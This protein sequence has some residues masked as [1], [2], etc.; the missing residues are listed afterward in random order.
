MAGHMAGHMAIFLG[1]ILKEKIIYYRIRELMNII[2][3]KQLILIGFSQFQ[4]VVLARFVSDLSA[5]KERKKPFAIAFEN[6]K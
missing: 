3:D 2:R 5:L 4:L 1:Y 6:L